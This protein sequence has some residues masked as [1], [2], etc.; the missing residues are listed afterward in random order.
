MLD[1]NL[2]ARADIRH[3]CEAWRL[4]P[5]AL[6]DNVAYMCRFWILA[7]FK[8]HK[9]FSI[10]IQISWQNT[11]LLIYGRDECIFMDAI[12]DT[13]NLMYYLFIQVIFYE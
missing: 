5:Y 12:F 2:W 11:T 7:S 8:G 10:G 9:D 6:V 3:F 1:A 4:S 13:N